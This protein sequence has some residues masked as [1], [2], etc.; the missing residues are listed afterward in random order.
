VKE[1][2][3]TKD[4]LNEAVDE[5]NPLAGLKLEVHAFNAPTK[6]GKDFTRVQW[7]LTE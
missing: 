4:M 2:D 7:A 1:V 6:A 3:L 5:E